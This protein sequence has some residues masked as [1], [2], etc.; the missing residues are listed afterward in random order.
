MNLENKKN[1]FLQKVKLIHGDKY[2][3]SKVD[4]KN[5]QT[6]ICIICKKHGE[7]WQRSSNHLMGINC[8]LCF[9]DSIRNKEFIK[10]SIKLHK[11]KYKYFK[12]DYKNTHTKVCIVCPIHGYFWCT[13]SNHLQHKSGCLK[14]W[15]T[16]RGKYDRSKSIH[17]G[18]L[19]GLTLKLFKKNP[20]LKNKQAI[21]YFIKFKNECKIGITTCDSLRR[22]FGY[23]KFKILKQRKTN[24]YRA[25][26]K[27]QSILKR[28]AIYRKISNNI[29]QG[30]TE[31]FLYS[32]KLE[33]DIK[34]LMC[35]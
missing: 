21:L 16:R 22:R 20:K 13:P 11:N 7:F 1:R 12:V 35:H 14:C 6:K 32:K 10:K 28:F 29:T 34:E 23:F 27:E 9:F 33:K 26:L 2:I 30:K 25:F 18:G 31:C 17:P 3:Y 4:Y 8:R 19:G 5:L 24:L 15:N